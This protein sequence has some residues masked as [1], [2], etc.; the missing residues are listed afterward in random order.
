MKFEYENETKD[1]QHMQSGAWRGGQ[2]GAIPRA[3]SHYGGAEWCQKVRGRQKVPTTSQ[4]LS[5]I[6]NI[7]FRKTSVS[8]TGA[9]N[10]L[11]APGAI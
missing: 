1:K 8:N 10:L 4:V 9:P 7:C 2:G 3:L 5:S 11:L 6:Q